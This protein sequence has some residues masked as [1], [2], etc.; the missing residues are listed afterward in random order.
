[1]GHPGQPALP[2]YAACFMLPAGEELLSVEIWGLDPATI[3]NTTR[4]APAPGHFPP[5]AGDAAAPVADI[6]TYQSSLPFPAED[7]LLSSLQS[8]SGVG[9]AFIN[10]YP[11]KVVP[12]SGRIIWYRSVAVVLHTGPSAEGMKP[13]RPGGVDRSVIRMI[14]NLE[15][16]ETVA[17]D[18]YSGT[19]ADRTDAAEHFPYVIV[20]SAQLAPHFEPLEGLKIAF[21]LRARTV[22]VDSISA[23]CP[24]I[25]L[26]ERIRNFIKDARSLWGTEFVL[27]GGDEEIIPHRSLYSKVGT[28]IEPDI[29]SDLYYAALDG[30]WNSDGDAYFGE[31]GEE[32]LIPEI[33]LGR[34]P[35]TSAVQIDN[36]FAKLQA[37]SLSPPVDACSRAL[38]V[39]EL[40][41]TGDDP[42]WGGDYKDE[43][44]GGTDN[45]GFTTAGI[46]PV[47]EIS[48]LYDRDLPSAWTEAALIPLLNAGQNLVNHLGHSNLHSV[49][50]IPIWDVGLL[51]NTVPENMPFI[52]YSQGC[53]AAAFDNR[54]DQGSF[55]ED[56]AIGEQLLTGPAGAVAF[57]GNT[58]LGW[59]TYGS[60][61][62]VSQYFD[63]QFFD[64]VFGEG[65]ATIGEAFDDSR[66]DNIPFIPYA[67]FRYVMYEMCLLGDPAMPVWT[68]APSYLAVGHD[69]IL[70]TGD[71]S[72][73]VEVLGG[74]G[75]V[76]G[77]RV[78]LSGN[79]PMIY[80]TAMTDENGVAYLYPGAGSEGAVA[81]SVAAPGFYLYSDSLPVEEESAANLYF[82]WFSID[83]DSEAGTMGDSDGIIESGETIGFDMAVRNNGASTA[84][85]S[86]LTAGCSDPFVTILSDTCGLGDMP[87]NTT[88]LLDDAVVIRISDG[89]PDGHSFNLDFILSCDGQTWNSRQAISIDAPGVA[90][91][92][93]SVSD[94]PNGNGNGC[95]EAW[96]YLKVHCS[97][98]NDGSS[99]IINPVISILAPEDGW[100]RVVRKYEALPDIPVGETVSS[101]GD[102]ELFVREFTPPFSDVAFFLTLEADNVAAR[103]ETLSFTTCG[104]GLEDDASAEGP[105]THGA[106][107]GY[108]GWHV[109]GEDFYSSPSCWKCGGGEGEIYPNMMNAV[110]V[111]PPLC[112]YDNSVLTFTH[113]MQAEATAVYPY[114]AEDAAVVEIST[115]AGATWTV[116]YPTVTYPNRAS[117]A[118]TISFPPY[119]RCYS[120]TI[121]WK[122]ETFNLSAWKGPVLIRFHFAT[123]EQIGFSGWFIDDISVTTEQ[124]TGDGDDPPSAAPVT[125]LLGAYPNPFNPS[126]SIQ[127]CVSGTSRVKMTL[128]DVAG[129]RV[130]A[131]LDKVHD[132]G[133]YSVSWDGRDDSGRRVASGVY[134]CRMDTGLY[135]AT[136]RLV[137]LK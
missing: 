36:F 34:L 37:Y 30:T 122:S 95:I 19:F 67:A 35:V 8:L 10:V 53:Y 6:E 119:Q 84:V 111:T 41:F 66:V 16:R 128:Y 92:S 78:S 17:A 12:S 135:S 45:Y 65:A 70:H 38:M 85:N 88:L 22:T 2:V 125:A 97:W 100:S 96:E 62:S 61:S 56:D 126:T 81:L 59:S 94:L 47:F 113:R 106:L 114:W 73:R 7:G 102:L 101:S 103:A 50:R 57:I 68:G 120:G 54:D 25:D 3:D 82:A 27:L 9:L 134:F 14:D 55:Y 42:T 91:A 4:V 83:D 121:G 58:R 124:L 43:I 40:L 98:F 63:R 74:S 127:Y 71:Q 32:D 136:R 80:C 132:G 130:R 1:M 64:A 11:C 15:N 86:S 21:G 72:L 116:V 49:M 69:S 89:A 39:G 129:R 115:D 77:A 90:L 99:D 110:L 48:T 137:L 24:G 131:L 23:A 28:E 109:T 112:L 104:N 60:T 46:P 44:A 118:N 117:A 79:D 31:P 52:C 29:P 20:T 93:W 133:S 51:A 26:Q 105:W 13:L 108:D 75:P 76:E 33:R 87:R 107:T 18:I 5:G 123:N